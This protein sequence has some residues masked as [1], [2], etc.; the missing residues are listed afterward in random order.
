[1]HDRSNEHQPVSYGSQC[2]VPVTRDE[3]PVALDGIVDD[4]GE[5][6]VAWRRDRQR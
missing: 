2:G 3:C 6:D 4:V 1:M 5:R